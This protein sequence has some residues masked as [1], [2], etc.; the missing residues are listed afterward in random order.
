MIKHEQ[1]TVATARAV[2]LK[3]MLMVLLTL[4]GIGV[5]VLALAIHYFGTATRGLADAHQLRYDSYLLADEMRQSSDDL[6]RLARTYVVT[7]DPRWQR[8]YQEVVDIRSGKAPRP[9][10]YQR[11]YW[12]F[13]AADQ[14]PGR[15]MGPAVALDEL[16]RRAGFT[17]QEFAKLGEAQARSA[18]LVHI[19]TVAMN[20]VK[21]LHDDGHGGLTRMDK[22]DQAAAIAMMH[23]ARYHAFKADI[24]KPVD[25]FFTLL[26]QRTQLAVETAQRAKQFWYSVVLALAGGLVLL[27]VGSLGWGYR[28]LTRSLDNAVQ[29][30]N[31]IAAGK[32][33]VTV[34]VQG[35]REVAQL[36]QGMATMRDQLAKVVLDVRNNA[37]TVAGACSDIARGN[38]DLSARTEEQAS[39]LEE[40]AASME[41]L[42]STVQQNA[43]NAKQADQLARGATEVAVKGGEMVSKVVNTMQGITESSRRISDIIGVIDG[44]AFQTNLLALNA[45][46]EAARAGEQGRGFAVV[47]AEVRGLSQRSAAAAKEIKELIMASVERVEQGTALVDQAGSTMTDMVAAI[48]RVTDIVAEISAASGEQSAGVSQ[49]GEAV[50][51][52]DIATQENAALVQRSA[53]AAEVLNDQASKLVAAVAVFDLGHAAGQVSEAVLMAPSHVADAV[54][55]A[56]WAS[57]DH[58]LLESARAA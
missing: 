18:E 20:M 8:Q 4:I 26:D 48:K 30:S 31:T 6:T 7:G 5:A 47:A 34:S 49:I 22:P 24:M 1:L 54:N 3:S 44:I 28:Q 56:G 33:D 40:T 52:M 16:M 50:S 23:D 12:D 37:D 55:P 27:L 14:D 36:L 32:L 43:E 38:I 58:A 57:Q 46:V 35:P 29:V 17:K 51:Q 45:A 41:E 39:A 11:I 42:S 2:S 13:R 53:E 10:Q 25:E 15:G 21:G 19:E 9:A